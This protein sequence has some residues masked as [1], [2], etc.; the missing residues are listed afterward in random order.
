MRCYDYTGIFLCVEID[1]A[2]ELISTHL[3]SLR[4]RENLVVNLHGTGRAFTARK[5]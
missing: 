4:S 2:A 3:F 1:M 5:V